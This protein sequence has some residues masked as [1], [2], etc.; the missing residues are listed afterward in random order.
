MCNKTALHILH[1]VR[2]LKCLSP[3]RCDWIAEK[4]FFA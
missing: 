1:D 3:A 4:L 2:S